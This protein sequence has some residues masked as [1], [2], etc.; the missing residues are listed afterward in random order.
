MEISGLT[1]L[2]SATVFIA[3]ILLAIIC[4]DCRNKSP[5]ASISQTPAS[6]EY[7]TSSGFSVI[8][9]CHPRPE[10]N[11]IHS[12]SN[13]MPHPNSADR[14]SE[15]R[16]RPYTPT[17]TGTDFPDSDAEDNGYIKVLPETE[18]SRAS[19][20]S[21]DNHYVNVEEAKPDS[22]SDSDPDYLNVDKIHQPCSTPD[23]SSQSEDDDNYVNQ[24]PMIPSA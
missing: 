3:T 22:D 11:A 12:P 20:P 8:H 2:L 17:E 14:G 15:R 21:S 19:T 16:L 4:L 23:L 18:P 10:P 7:V 5:L 24:P 9:P 13:L 6:D 1:L